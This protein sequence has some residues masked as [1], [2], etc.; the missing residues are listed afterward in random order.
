MNVETRITAMERRVGVLQR[1]NARLRTAVAVIA[2][3][4][5]AAVT[6]AANS[7]HT[8]VQTSLLEIM[9]DDGTVA[10]SMDQYGLAVTRVI[11][12][13]GPNQATIVSLD[14]D[15]IYSF[16]DLYAPN[17]KTDELKII[18]T[19]LHKSLTLNILKLEM[20]EGAT[21]LTST[22]KASVVEARLKTSELEVINGQ[23]STR[24]WLGIHE[25]DS[26]ALQLYKDDDNMLIADPTG[27]S[28]MEEGAYK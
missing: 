2:L 10:A 26:P 20:P 15:G 7:A 27:I 28:I 23:G 19:D 17:I 18:D 11:V 6:I 16:E 24:A 22:I 4:M 1:Q 14:E 8:P 13:E 9:A 12:R 5:V 25:D 21:L 3:S